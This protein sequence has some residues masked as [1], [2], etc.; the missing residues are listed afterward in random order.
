[1][2][3]ETLSIEKYS[4]LITALL[5]YYC[6]VFI[7]FVSINTYVISR[8]MI[9]MIVSYSL[10]RLTNIWV[11]L[12]HDL[13]ISNSKC[14]RKS[15]TINRRLKWKR[16]RKDVFFIWLYLQQSEI[17]SHFKLIR[18]LLSHT[19]GVRSLL[20]QSVHWLRLL[21][22]IRYFLIEK[23][24]FHVQQWFYRIVRKY[25][26]VLYVF[27]TRKIINNSCHGH[28]ESLQRMPCRMIYQKLIYM[29]A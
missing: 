19:E 7:F 26:K 11:H 9:W 2:I 1:M 27:S 16:I 6:S 8:N 21:I 14:N 24:I 25:S 29:L 12:A 23:K 15:R 20:R 5:K 22:F 4:T 3:V 17:C 10:Y 13:Y 28:T 18:R